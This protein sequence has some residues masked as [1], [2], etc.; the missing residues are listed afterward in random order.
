MG[1]VPQPVLQYVLYKRR[2]VGRKLARAIALAG[3]PDPKA[4]LESK[5]GPL[6]HYE[7]VQR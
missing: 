1:N 6:V 5:F 3:V 2:G 7:V 4:W